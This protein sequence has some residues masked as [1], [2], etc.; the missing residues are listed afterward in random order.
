MTYRQAIIAH[1]SVT[2]F[3][4]GVV[5]FVQLVQLPLLSRVGREGFCAYHQTLARRAGWM[6]IG[7]VIAELASAGALLWLAPPGPSWLALFGAVLL[8]VIWTSTLAIQLPLH[9][10]LQAGFDEA[11]IR[12]L[13]LTSWVRT[14]AWTLRFAT[15]LAFFFL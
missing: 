10:R 8:A 3:M 14:G 15:A 1:A 12:R 2:F 9:R 5:W 7:P 4:T 11:V 6:L 13:V